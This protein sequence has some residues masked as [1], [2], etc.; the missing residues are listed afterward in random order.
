[1]GQHDE[2]LVLALFTLASL[3]NAVNGP[4]VI[5]DRLINQPAVNTLP[6]EGYGNPSWWGPLV[7]KIQETNRYPNCKYIFHQS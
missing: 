6:I 7:K 1:M 5:I 4:E 2:W 3:S